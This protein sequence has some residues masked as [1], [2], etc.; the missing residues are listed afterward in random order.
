[1]NIAPVKSTPLIIIS[2]RKRDSFIAG[3]IHGNNYLWILHYFEK[4]EAIFKELPFRSG[5]LKLRTLQATLILTDVIDRTP[6]ANKF[7]TSPIT[8]RLECPT[9]VMIDFYKQPIDSSLIEKMFEKI[10]ILISFDHE[11]F[12]AFEIWIECDR[13]FTRR[14]IST[15]IS[16][17]SIIY[18]SCSKYANFTVHLAFLRLY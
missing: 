5:S 4:N 6:A 9:A 7:L 11:K 8:I 10:C 15:R 16:P 3:L 17:I 13:W 1:M 14:R 2:T 12:V 18:H